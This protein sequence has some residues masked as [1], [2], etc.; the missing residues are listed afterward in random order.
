MNTFTYAT[1]RTYNGPQILTITFPDVVED[2]DMLDDI[3]V[4]FVDHSRNIKGSVRMMVCFLLSSK[5]SIGKDVLSMYDKGLYT[6][7]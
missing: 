4:T 3:D 6:L 7:I 1:E 5:A 2:E